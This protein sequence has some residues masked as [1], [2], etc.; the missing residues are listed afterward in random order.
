MGFLPK[1]L[2]SI[3]ECQEIISGEILTFGKKY[4][5]AKNAETLSTTRGKPSF[6]QMENI[7]FSI[8]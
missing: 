6:V 3:I 8:Q 2:A 7:Y 4:D 1:I 5:I